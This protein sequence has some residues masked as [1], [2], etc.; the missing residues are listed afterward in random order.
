MPT[1]QFQK[2]TDYPLTNSET[3]FYVVNSWAFLQMVAKGGDIYLSYLSTPHGA[4]MGR[5]YELLE[6]WQK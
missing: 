6:V 3:K 4:E 1:I 5:I 2:P